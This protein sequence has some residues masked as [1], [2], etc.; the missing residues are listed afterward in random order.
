MLKSEQELNEGRFGNFAKAA[1]LGASLAFAPMTHATEIP[2]E[3]VPTELAKS[4]NLKHDISMTDAQQMAELALTKVGDAAMDD[5]PVGSKAWRN[6]ESTYKQ[7]ANLDYKVATAFLGK[8]NS[9][10]KKLF[11]VQI[12]PVPPNTVA[13]STDLNEVLWDDNA[14]GTDDFETWK[15]QVV[16]LMNDGILDLTVMSDKD[17]QE[18]EKLL[19]Y[20]F[21][22]KSLPPIGAA[23]WIAR[24][25]KKFM[26]TNK[27][28]FMT[29]EEIAFK[30]KMDAA[31][32]DKF[33]SQDV[34]NTV[35]DPGWRGPNGA[36]SLD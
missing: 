33:A 9:S 1:A 13:E 35:E 14:R 27:S 15:A 17:V 26:Q 36:W 25:M 24:D 32:A 7:L 30:R 8:F 2:L 12:R 20:Y 10:A 11:G 28:K 18:C 5:D 3:K 19:K 16:D 34:A 29:P 4:Y 6:A 31:I 23:R 21:K 22:Q